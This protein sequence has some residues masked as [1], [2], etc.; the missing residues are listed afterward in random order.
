MRSRPNR[1]RR[2]SARW[3]ERD[4]ITAYS[5]NPQVRPWARRILSRGFTLL[6]NVL[7]GQ[8]LSYYNGPN[9]YSAE[10]LAGLPNATVGFAFHAE[11]VTRL[12]RDGRSVAPVGMRLRPQPGRRSQALRVRNVVGVLAD[13]ARLFWTLRVRPG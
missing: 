1:S 4:V 5:V 10:Q 7:F 12:L 9:V 11:L 3:V 8:R 6:I 13:V 2:Y